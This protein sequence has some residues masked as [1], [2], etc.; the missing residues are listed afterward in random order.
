[1]SQLR[2]A[3][4][5]RLEPSP[6]RIRSR[7]PF[8]I[9]TTDCSTYPPSNSCDAPVERLARPEATAASWSA[10]S[11]GMCSL[12][13]ISR[14]SADTSTACETPDTSR[15]NLETSQS[16]ESRCVDRGGKVMRYRFL[17]FLWHV[18]DRHA[19]HRN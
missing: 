4:V 17:W 2:V 9:S 18:I 6:T 15:A 12:A 7:Y 11:V 13:A 16:S 1:M 3:S 8:S 14:P 5:A 10:R 19:H